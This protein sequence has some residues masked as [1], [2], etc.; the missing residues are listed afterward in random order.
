M[1]CNKARLIDM[2][3][4]G[5]KIW[6][7]VIV[8]AKQV[9]PTVL[10]SLL[11]I[12]VLKKLIILI[13]ILIYEYEYDDDDNH[14]QSLSPGVDC[15]G[16]LEAARRFTD[17]Q[18]LHTGYRL[19]LVIVNIVTTT[20]AIV[21]ITIVIVIIT[22]VIVVIIILTSLPLLIIILHFRF[23]S[24]PTISAQQRDKFLCPDN[25]ELFNVKT[26]QEV[27]HTTT[28]TII[29][30]MANCQFKSPS[31]PNHF[32]L[33]VAGLVRELLSQLGPPVQVEIDRPRDDGTLRRV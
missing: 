11:K 5:G 3:L 24:D 33:Q 31:S 1:S 26:D 12:V 21:T 16:A 2:F 6:K 15:Q 7:N 19:V 10:C 14:D 9:G 20:I 8:V 4:A 29:T 17:D 28:L 13:L 32:L 23:L 27:T 25:R 22:I 18:V 30:I